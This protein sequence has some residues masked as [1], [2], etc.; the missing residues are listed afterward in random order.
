MT[1]NGYAL[2]ARAREITFSI[3][4]A[5]SVSL[6]LF[7]ASGQLVA[8]LVDGV[9]PAGEHVAIW[10]GRTVRGNRAA[11]GVYF[12]KLETPGHTMTCRAVLAR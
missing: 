1:P 4:Q 5:T 9:R 10:D 3:P 8:R 2:S 12:V 7:G 11:S 6:G